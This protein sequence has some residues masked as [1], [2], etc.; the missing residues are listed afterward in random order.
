[1]EP[2]IAI[3]AD[4]WWQA[5]QARKQLKVDWD[6]GPQPRK[7]VKASG[8]EQ[9]N[10]FK[11]RPE[12][13]CARMAMWT[14]RSSHRQRSSKPPMNIRSLHTYAGATGRYGALERRQ[15]GDVV[16]QYIAGGR[17]QTGSQDAW[18]PR[19]RYHYSHG[20]RGRQLWPA[21]P[22]TTTWSKPH[23]LPSA[24][25]C[26]SSCSGPAKMTLPTTPSAPA[27]PLG[28]KPAWMRRARSRPAAALCHLWR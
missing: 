27:E 1:M 24:L 19:G 6:L 26:R 5:Q 20:A 21:A 10:F 12:P 8:S 23:G 16:D 2:G 22:E 14:R 4:T 7:A 9:R 3:V 28:L 15:A 25:T 17:S 11:P 13:P 18:H